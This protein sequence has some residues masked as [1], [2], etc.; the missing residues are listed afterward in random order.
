MT[1]DFVWGRSRSKKAKYVHLY[2][3]GTACCGQGP[4]MDLLNENWDPDAPETC[5]HCKEYYQWVK[6]GFHKVPSQ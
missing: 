2:T 5:K 6:R 1:E 4:R 3:N